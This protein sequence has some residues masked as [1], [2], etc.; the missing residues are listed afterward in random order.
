MDHK[1]Y[2][3]LT[4]RVRFRQMNSS[5]RQATGPPTRTPTGRG[6]GFKV[7]VVPEPTVI[8]R[9]LESVAEKHLWL[10]AVGVPAIVGLA[11]Y[12][13]WIG[14]S[15]DQ[16]SHVT[17]EAQSNLAPLV[18]GVRAE[19]GARAGAPDQSANANQGTNLVVGLPEDPSS[20]KQ[21]PTIGSDTT[22]DSVTTT[23]RESAAPTSAKDSL[24]QASS[25]ST[26]ATSTTST[27]RAEPTTTT[28]KPTTTTTHL[29]TTTI[30]FR[31]SAKTRSNVHLM[32][33]PGTMDK[34]DS[35]DRGTRLSTLSAVEV[36]GDWWIRIESKPGLV[37]GWIRLSTVKIYTEECKRLV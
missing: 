30:E 11:V 2:D 4:L 21:G 3:A 8:T 19:S 15:P 13:V 14:V 17:T 18:A 33:N 34:V 23:S 32:A 27:T 10:L 37:E 9:T 7:E 31:C 22:E 36:D 1:S 26:A 24:N 16:S 35:V 5:S 25:R 6:P 29:T 12:I 20:P 28:T